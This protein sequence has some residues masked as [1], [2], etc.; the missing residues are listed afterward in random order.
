MTDEELVLFVTMVVSTVLS[1]ALVM[2]II[3]T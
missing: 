3:L 2:F 1:A